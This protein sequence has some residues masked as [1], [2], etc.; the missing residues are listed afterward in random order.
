MQYRRSSRIFLKYGIGFMSKSGNKLKA[1]FAIA[2]AIYI[3][4]CQ[5]I[6]LVWKTPFYGDWINHVWMVE[7]YAN[8]LRE[9]GN[10]PGT[11]DAEQAF[12]NPS[13]L[14]YG[15][16]LYPLISLIALITGAD[17][18]VRLFAAT[19]LL[20]PVIS[21]TFLLRKI[22]SET[23]L[24][25][26][27]ACVLSASVYQLTNLYFRSALTE[28]FAAQ[29]LLLGLSLLFFGLIIKRAQGAFISCG[30]AFVVLA[31][32]THPITAYTFSIF[33]VPILIGSFITLRKLFDRKALISILLCCAAALMVLTPWLLIVLQTQSD[34]QISAFA[35]IRYFPESIDS[36][37]ARLGFFY[38]DPR[39]AKAG[40][41]GYTSTPFL[42]A[43]FAIPPTIILAVMLAH[44]LSRRRRQ[45]LLIAIP[46]ILVMLS[47]AYATHEPDEADGNF[48][49]ALL[50][51]IQFVYRLAGTWSIAVA[52]A[53]LVLIVAYSRSNE[54]QP[55]TTPFMRITVTAAALLCAF[56]V[57]QKLYVANI[58][59]QRFPQETMFDPK[60]EKAVHPLF[61]G[62]ARYLAEIRRSN[63]YPE[64]YYAMLDYS[65]PG[66]L[67][68]TIPS[69]LKT[70]VLTVS[71]WGPQDAI[72]SDVAMVIQT[73]ILPSPTT[74]VT[75]DGR[76]ADNFT[77][78]S[79]GTLD[80]RVGPGLH[81]LSV[82]KIGRRFAASQFSIFAMLAWLFISCVYLLV[83]NATIRQKGRSLYTQ[84][85]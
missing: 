43:P 72:S 25:I 21:I 62:Y 41:I 47:L 67:Q 54:R 69:A 19:M 50:Q 58:E 73:N 23:A 84:V 42:D 60:F 75:I 17:L 28:F 59:F 8:H 85:G 14:Y 46:T 44:G 20:A 33:V 26:L 15:F 29:F 64:M 51:P 80:F 76:P 74:R 30:A 48:A 31:C 39:I 1:G 36:L 38:Y 71:K 2:L 32:G 61:M 55:V 77:L 13:P 57:S 63:R 53:T 6:P 65:I 18:A 52:T 12:G 68:K 34:L 22:L 78:S 10:F 5:S 56:S 82:E 83:E 27:L 24:S 7:Y 3:F 11:F 45:F 4:L 37:V 70:S 40:G 16:L 79:G 49:F 9:N 66:D 81:V 35:R